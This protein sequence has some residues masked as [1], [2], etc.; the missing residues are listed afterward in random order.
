[1]VPENVGNAALRAVK[2]TLAP[3]QSIMQ[4]E[5]RSMPRRV[6]GAMAEAETLRRRKK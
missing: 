1:M 6:T 4:D 2:E 3:R 5:V